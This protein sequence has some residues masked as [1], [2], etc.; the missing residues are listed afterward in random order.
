LKKY[1][2]L[3]TEQER[4]PKFLTDLSAPRYDPNAPETALDRKHRE[5]RCICL[6]ESIDRKAHRSK[7]DLV[8]DGPIKYDGQALYRK[9]E[10]FFGCGKI[11]G[12]VTG[13][14]IDLRKHS[15]SHSKMK[16]VEFGRS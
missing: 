13:A 3:L 7:I 15:M 9:M 4:W 1:F 11:D 8:L 16:I 12:D 5:E 14:G 2:E 6:S 10:D